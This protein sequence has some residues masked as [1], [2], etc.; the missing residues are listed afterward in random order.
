MESVVVRRDVLYAPPDANR[1][2]DI[3]EPPQVAPDLTRTV[4][5]IAG[6]YPDPSPARGYRHLGWTE[7]MARLIAASGITAVSYGTEQPAADVY[8][9][10]RWARNGGATREVAPGRVGI[11]ASS[12]NGPAALSTLLKREGASPDFAV[13]AYACL[14][15]VDGA[16]D[17]AEA[18]RMFG[19][20]NPL[21]G[22]SIED[23][24]SGVPILIVRAGQDQFRAM[25]ASQDRFVRSAQERNFPISLLN[26]PA[27]V[28]AF[29]LLDDTPH[30]QQVVQSMLTFMRTTV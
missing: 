7:S 27:G 15:D 23:F 26:Y 19:F 13:F 28:H 24:E 8:S 17:V 18:S 9:V 14:L 2:A 21:A 3:Y 10:L 29:D 12:G 30:S 1:L 25:N 5:V 20:V 16:T 4:V 11:L 6:G 22:A